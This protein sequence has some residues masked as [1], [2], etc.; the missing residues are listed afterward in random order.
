MVMKRGTYDFLLLCFAVVIG[1]GGCTQHETEGDGAGVETPANPVVYE[2]E[3]PTGSGSASGGLPDTRSSAIR[4]KPGA[5]VSLEYAVQAKPRIGERLGIDLIFTVDAPGEL[6]Q[7]SCTVGNGLLLRNAEFTL[8]D[9]TAG[10]STSHSIEVTPQAHGLYYVNV[11]V[12]M[13]TG[14][15]NMARTFAVPVQVGDATDPGLKQ[16]G[17]LGKDEAGE[18]IISLP[19]KE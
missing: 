11:I 15:R 6:L 3:A 1:L 4:G 19:A 13:K 5:P 12:Q 17:T 9:V 2:G 8:S 7:V 18:G 10:Q 16:E 14:E